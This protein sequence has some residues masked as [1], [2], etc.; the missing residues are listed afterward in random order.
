MCQCVIAITV[1]LAYFCGHFSGNKRTFEA[2][3]PVLCYI[4]PLQK[5]LYVDY[6]GVNSEQSWQAGMPIYFVSP[7]AIL[8]T[9]SVT[10]KTRTISTDRVS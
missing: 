5:S 9:S 3:Y 8:L 10:S 7:S 4:G 2:F 6:F 1:S